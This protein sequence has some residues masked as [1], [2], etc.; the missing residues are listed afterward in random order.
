MYVLWVIATQLLKTLLA[1][2]MAAVHHHRGI[3]LRGLLL[4]DRASKDRME[5]G[6]VRQRDLNLP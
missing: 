6:V 2:D 4:G 1:N 3:F 5:F